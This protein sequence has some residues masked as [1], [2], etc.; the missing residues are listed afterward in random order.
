MRNLIAYAY[1]LGLICAFEVLAGTCIMSRSRSQGCISWCSERS[2]SSEVV[3][4]VRKQDRQMESIVP[5]SLR[6]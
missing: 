5:S 3:T 1:G 4:T 6:R 2:T